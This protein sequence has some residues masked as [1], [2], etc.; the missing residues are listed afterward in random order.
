MPI[1][2]K[3]AYKKRQPRRI[4]DE[5]QPNERQLHLPLMHVGLVDAWV[6]CIMVIFQVFGGNGYG[7]GVFAAFRR[8]DLVYNRRG[9]RLSCMDFRGK[10][11]S[12]IM[13]QTC[14]QGQEKGRFFQEKSL[15]G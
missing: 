15:F 13:G 6:Y 2:Y 7:V 5:P 14:K 9:W 12:A 11:P 8:S 3:N 4:F 1:D 10:W